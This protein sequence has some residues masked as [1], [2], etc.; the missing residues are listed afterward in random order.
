MDTTSNHIL[1][2]EQDT[3]A[4]KAQQLIL[5][6]FGINI[7]E[8]DLVKYSIKNG[9][10]V[11]DDG[12]RKSD[13]GRLLDA[14]KIP[15]ASKEDA[16]MYDLVNQLQQGHKVIVGVD[17]GELWKEDSLWARLQE[18]F[19]DLFG[20]KADHTIIVAGIDASNPHDVKV[21]VTDPGTG[22][23]EKAYPLA[24]FMDAWQDSKF[25]MCSTTVAPPEIAQQY[26]ENAEKTGDDTWKNME[27]PQVANVDNETFHQFVDYSH[28]IDPVNFNMQMPVLYNSFCNMPMNPGWGINDALSFNHLPAYNT[29]MSVQPLCPV[30]SPIMPWDF[31]Y[32]SCLDTSWMYEPYTP[33][34]LPPVQPMPMF[35]PVFQPISTPWYNPVNNMTWNMPSTPMPTPFSPIDEDPIPGGDVGDVSDDTPTEIEEPTETHEELSDELDEVEVATSNIEVPTDSIG[36]PDLELDEDEE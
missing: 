32:N 9:W 15:C 24:D 31:D 20:G 2:G 3:C 7:S 8:A 18:W 25:L 29:I 17:S 1:Q 13:I 22:D 36:F 26:Q 19:K 30:P 14:A 34:F 35:D 5:E 11:K 10:Y 4:I 16:T 12:T 28:C 23:K 21:L 27:M 33:M 6:D